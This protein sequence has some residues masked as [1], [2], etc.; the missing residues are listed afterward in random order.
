MGSPRRNG[1]MSILIVARLRPLARQLSHRRHLGTHGVQLGYASRTADELLVVTSNAL[2]A[3]AEL[4]GK[5]WSRAGPERLA[6][7]PCPPA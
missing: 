4:C 3:S 7:P 2:E 1:R 5:A 6:G